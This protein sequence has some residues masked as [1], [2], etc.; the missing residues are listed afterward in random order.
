MKAAI[1]QVI[2]TLQEHWDLQLLKGAK[3]V[4]VTETDEY[5]ILSDGK[6]VWVNKPVLVGRFSRFGLDVH[7]PE[8][9]DG[10]HCIH[11]TTGLPTPADWET[12]VAA[13]V[14]HFD[15]VVPDKHKPKWLGR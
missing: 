11:C 9:C 10:G 15:V 8:I 5:Q 3:G 6:T 2:R 7:K 4:V 13:M 14:E 1:K 12:F